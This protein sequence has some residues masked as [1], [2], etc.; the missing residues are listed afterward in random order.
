MRG[1]FLDTAGWFAAMAPPEE[2]HKSAREAYAK[3]AQGGVELVTTP[4]VIA[5]M[6]VLVLRWR[7]VEQGERFLS[8]AFDSA[9]HRVVTPAAD[10][11]ES[12]ID[13]W[14]RRYDDQTF[15]L[16]DAISFEVMQR[17]RLV[18]ALTFDRHFATAGFE[19]L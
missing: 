14:I 7:G 8:V 16:C 13:R 17:E 12:A 3:A 11:M 10:L 4:F 2:G 9:A 5:E 6:H 19:I 15:S 1:V 18:K